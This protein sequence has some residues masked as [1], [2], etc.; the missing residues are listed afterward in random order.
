MEELINYTIVAVIAFWIGWRV[1]TAIILAKMSLQPEK[2][3]KLLE[4]VKA[5]NDKEL[6]SDSGIEQISSDE[7]RIERVGE[8]L[9]AYTKHNN[10]FIAQG[11]DLESVLNSAHRRFPDRTFFGTI[12]STNSAKEIAISN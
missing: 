12:E 2:M 3:I 5:I 1:R 4:Q 9:Y 10:E 8:Q 11:N 7:L 6:D